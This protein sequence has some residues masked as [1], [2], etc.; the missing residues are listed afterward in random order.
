MIVGWRI[1]KPCKRFAVG[2]GPFRLHKP[3]AFTGE[4]TACPNS[5]KIFSRPNF[6]QALRFGENTIWICYVEFCCPIAWSSQL[7]VFK[8]AGSVKEANQPIKQKNPNLDSLH[9]LTHLFL[10]ARLFSQFLQKD[11]EHIFLVSLEGI[12]MVL[13]Q[14]L[15]EYCMN[16]I[17]GKLI[18]IWT[19]PT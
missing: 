16:S 7:A 14:F 12:T 1:S 5:K 9:F 4:N 19:S 8:R 6:Q 2:R 11:R 17:S 18:W 13:F 10:N 15:L 3:M